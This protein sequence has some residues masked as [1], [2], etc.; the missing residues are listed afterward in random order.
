MLAQ[1]VMVFLKDRKK[2]LEDEAN[3]KAKEYQTDVTPSK[4]YDLI[5]MEK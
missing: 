5:Q 2:Q 1:E 3:I 4:Y